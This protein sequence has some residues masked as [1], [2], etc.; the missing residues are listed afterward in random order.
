[1][2]PVDIV[3]FFHKCATWC[4]VRRFQALG[5]RGG[6]ML[7]TCATDLDQN[8]YAH[9]VAFIGRV[10]ARGGPPNSYAFSLDMA[11]IADVSTQTIHSNICKNT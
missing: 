6:K 4:H 1:M 11:N 7:E 8:G 10:V 2:G 3:E 9:I 5:W